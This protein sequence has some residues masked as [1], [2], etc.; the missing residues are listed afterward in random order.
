MQRDIFEDQQ[1]FYN[2][3]EITTLF[4]KCK[5]RPKEREFFNKAPSQESQQEKLF[6]TTNCMYM[7]MQRKES[8]SFTNP[9]MV[10]A[11]KLRFFSPV[12]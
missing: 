11:A 8:E 10:L 6:S 7:Y 5:V 12:A 9:S 4:L 1:E 3:Q 2:Q